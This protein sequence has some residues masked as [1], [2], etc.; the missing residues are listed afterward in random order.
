MLPLR[1]SRG[2]AGRFGRVG[3]RDDVSD[4]LHFAVTIGR[5]RSPVNKV[6]ME[7]RTRTR[8]VILHDTLVYRYSLISIACCADG[9]MRTVE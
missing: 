2:V 9:R 7:N 8:Y 1:E 6:S 3:R 4:V 5:E